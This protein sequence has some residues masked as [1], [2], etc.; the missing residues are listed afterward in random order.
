MRPAVR[1]PL[2]PVAAAEAEILRPRVSVR[3]AA[4]PRLQMQHGMTQG[5]SIRRCRSPVFRGRLVRRDRGW[6]GGGG[7]GYAGTARSGRSLRRFGGGSARGVADRAPARSRIGTA[8]SGQSQAMQFA[9]DGVAMGEAHAFRDFGAAQLL[10]HP[11]ACQFGHALFR[12]ES[13][14]A[15]D[16]YPSPPSA[17]SARLRCFVEG[18]TFPRGHPIDE[19]MK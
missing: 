3:P 8:L 12:P 16:R 18:W 10:V 15:H 4:V 9:H 13:L 6:N 11:E 19:G 17:R 7:I 14:D 2:L 5:R 1:G